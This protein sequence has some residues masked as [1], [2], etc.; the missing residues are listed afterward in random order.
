[1]KIKRERE[2]EYLPP[3]LKRIHYTQPS[4]NQICIS[5]PEVKSF[6]KLLSKH[7]YSNTILVVITTKMRILITTIEQKVKTT[8]TITHSNQQ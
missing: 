8:K 6:C 4:S 5:T 3:V 1:M 7:F 2:G